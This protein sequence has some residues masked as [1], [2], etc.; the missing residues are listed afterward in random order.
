VLMSSFSR[1]LGR[2]ARW[3]WYQDKQALG[4]GITATAGSDA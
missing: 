1:L 3:C 4:T 2:P